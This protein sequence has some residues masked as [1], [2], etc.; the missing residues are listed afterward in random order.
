MGTAYRFV[1]LAKSNP[2][3]KVTSNWDAEERHAAHGNTTELSSLKGTFTKMFRS[4][5][6]KG[7]A[8]KCQTTALNDSCGDGETL[9]N[10]STARDE[11]L[12][13][14]PTHTDADSTD[15]YCDSTY[16]DADSFKSD[17]DREESETDEPSSETSE[18]HRKRN[19]TFPMYMGITT[20]TTFECRRGDEAINNHL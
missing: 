12:S 8:S 9:L 20:A 18:G 2:T 1:S 17:S 7:T 6:I 16:L 3:G 19:D 11:A 13:V 14:E 10:D 4:T 5:P 15:F